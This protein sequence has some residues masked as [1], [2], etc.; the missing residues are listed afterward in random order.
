MK[1]KSWWC[2]ILLNVIEIAFKWTR[3]SGECW[4]TECWAGESIKFPESRERIQLFEW[5]SKWSNKRPPLV[6]TAAH[7]TSI[8]SISISCPFNCFQEFLRPPQKLRSMQ[9][10]KRENESERYFI[11]DF[12]LT[13]SSRSRVKFRFK[14][15]SPEW[16][17]GCRVWWRRGVRKFPSIFSEPRGIPG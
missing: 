17:L 13:H 1:Y 14:W 15:F 9:S 6:S 16:I 4:P 3:W 2:N 8:L 12:R 11:G 7:G 10:L 5:K